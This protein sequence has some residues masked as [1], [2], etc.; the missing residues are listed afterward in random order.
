MMNCVITRNFDLEDQ[1]AARRKATGEDKVFS[2]EDHNRALADAVSK[3]KEEAYQ[4][5]Y[6]AGEEAAKASILEGCSK[7]LEMIAPQMKEFLDA[8]TTHQRTLE[9]EVADFALSIGQ[10]V[11]PDL[12]EQ[13]SWERAREE[14]KRVLEKCI[15]RPKLK[16]FV[17]AEVHETMA[18]DLEELAATVDH[19]QTVEIVVDK[20]FSN[21][22][23]KV[24]WDDGFMSYSFEDVC[25]EIMKTVTAVQKT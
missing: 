6:N 17:S 19:G 7:T 14:I 23:A 4:E 13:V 12:V 25:N 20:E 3:A 22:D 16:I 21:G 11:F 15:G 2:L 1:E 9:T 8:T 5:G 18:D 10:K 24:V